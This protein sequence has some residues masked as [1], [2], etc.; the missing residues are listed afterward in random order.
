MLLIVKK[1]S[2]NRFARSLPYGKPSDVSINLNAPRVSAS[3]KMTAEG[4]FLQ[5]SRVVV[6]AKRLVDYNL[7]ACL[8][9]RSLKHFTNL[10]FIVN[11]IRPSLV[12]IFSILILGIEFC[13]VIKI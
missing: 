6:V 4:S 13:V 12:F 10:S 9:T 2:D 11:F 1:A 8:G 7:Q 5:I 3:L